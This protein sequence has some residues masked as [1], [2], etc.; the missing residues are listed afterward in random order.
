M[1]AYSGRADGGR[2]GAPVVVADET[3]YVS[4]PDGT[5]RVAWFPGNRHRLVKP[6]MRSGGVAVLDEGLQ[7]ASQVLLIW[8]EQVVEA[9]LLHRPD[10]PLV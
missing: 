9:L 6:L 4:S 10:P 7:D 2:I 5:H 8:D 3:Q 1:S